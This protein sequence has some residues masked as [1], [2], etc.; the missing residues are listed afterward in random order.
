MVEA[1]VSDDAF[2]SAWDGNVYTAPSQN[3]IYDY[4]STVISDDAY[5]AGWETENN[6]G[7]SRAALYTKIQTLFGPSGN[8]IPDTNITYTIGNADYAFLSAYVRDI[9]VDNIYERTGAGNINVENN[10]DA[11]GFIGTFASLVVP[12]IGNGGGAVA[13]T[14]ILNMGGHS[15]TGAIIS[16][17]TP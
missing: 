4:M 6:T 1:C 17:G 16:G 10:L 13:F 7:A 9:Y 11:T 8:L 5:G 15:I 12:S 2:S 14:D 3:A